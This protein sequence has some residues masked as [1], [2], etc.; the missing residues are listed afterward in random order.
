MIDLQKCVF[1]P[2]AQNFLL[3]DP[4]F[5]RIIFRPQLPLPQALIL[6]RLEASLQLNI[7][8]SLSSTHRMHDCTDFR[9]RNFTKFEHSTSI[10]VAMNPG[11]E[12]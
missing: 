4:Y 7:L 5:Q 9:Q 3:V 11:T 10:C 8:D 1:C 2:I 12:L 6:V